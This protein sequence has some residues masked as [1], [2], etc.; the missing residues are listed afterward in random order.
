MNIKDDDNEY[1]EKKPDGY[2]HMMLHKYEISMFP[3]EGRLDSPFET[4]FTSVNTEEGKGET[5]RELVPSGQSK[6]PGA[7]AKEK[8]IL[9]VI[10]Q[11]R[12]IR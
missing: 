9:T 5:R 7:S 11:E 8:G 12:T 4:Y 10:T 1:D 6:R 2:Y 3:L